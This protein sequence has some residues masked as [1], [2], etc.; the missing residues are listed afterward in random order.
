MF[1][2][3]LVVFLLLN[4]LLPWS[5]WLF[6]D[7]CHA[8]EIWDLGFDELFSDNSELRMASERE[9][10]EMKGVTPKSI[11]FFRHDSLKLH[12][13]QDTVRP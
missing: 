11:T 2:D 5:K 9:G 13:N 1:A 7:F 8:A 12:R 10:M 6:C 3:V 4:K